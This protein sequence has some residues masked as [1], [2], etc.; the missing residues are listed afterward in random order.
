MN[1]IMR[2]YYESKNMSNIMKH[3]P[4]VSWNTGTPKSSM[5]DWD[6]PYTLW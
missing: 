2:T 1:N 6:F 5:F 3:E 4:E